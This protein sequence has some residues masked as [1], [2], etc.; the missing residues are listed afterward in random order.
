MEK[1]TKIQIKLHCPKGQHN[2]FGGY[3]YRSL[4]DIMEAVKPLL[5]GATVTFSDEVIAVGN[6]VFVKATA[7]FQDG[8][9][10]VE[11]TGW[12]QHDPTKKGMDG[13]QITGACSSYARKYAANGLFLIDD[14][15]DAD[16]TNRHG[17][18]QLPNTSPKR[19]TKADGD[20]IRTAREKVGLSM[21]GVM[22]IAN[23]APYSVGGNMR[24]L[25]KVHVPKL[26]DEIQK[27]GTNK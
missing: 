9:E 15:R 3:N 13:A 22:V 11:T 17:N 12:A 1:L 20:K 7:R 10:A 25:L 8:D 21:D 23:S 27:Q 18:K 4:E 26:I 24:N 6:R 2:S 16:A 19:I 5:D 14:T